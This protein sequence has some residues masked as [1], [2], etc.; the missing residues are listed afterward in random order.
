MT[1]R[2][3]K[4]REV[5]VV[6]ATG[7]LGARRKIEQ[8]VLGLAAVWLVLFG[9]G[10]ALGL[11]L[12]GRHGGGPIQGWDNQVERWATAH[13]LGLVGVSKVIAFLGD[14]P[15]LAVIVVVITAVLLWRMRSPR[16]LVL[17]AAYLGAEVGVFAIRAVVHRH[18]PVTANF[19]APGAVRGVHETSWSFPSGHAVAVT[20]VLLAGA[21]MIAL[22]RHWWWP[23]VVAGVLSLAVAD[24]RLVLGVHW[25]SDV[26]IGLCLGAVWGIAAVVVGHWATIPD[27][28]TAPVHRGAKRRPSS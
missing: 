24:S 21:G 26:A 3:I 17:L 4:P 7:R 9:V 12:V 18:R 22:V 19:P 6:D 20:A 16:S 25:F 13:R 27:A 1:D 14:A 11:A 5:D 15:K 28:G 8:G 10:L 23:W 2:G